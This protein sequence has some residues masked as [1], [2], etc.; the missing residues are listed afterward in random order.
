MEEKLH[1]LMIALHIEITSWE[2]S[3]RREIQSLH[4]SQPQPSFGG[5]ATISQLSISSN[6]YFFPLAPPSP[7]SPQKIIW[8]FSPTV[9][10]TPSRSPQQKVLK[11]LLS[12]IRLLRSLNGSSGL[13]CAGF[14]IPLS[15]S[16]FGMRPVRFVRKHV[17]RPSRGGYVG[18]LTR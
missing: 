12:F 18:W 4:N 15:A 5:A 17:S 14:K 13:F 8:G 10:R 16:Q 3:C 6:K 9:T 11:F 7:P 1:G 2:K